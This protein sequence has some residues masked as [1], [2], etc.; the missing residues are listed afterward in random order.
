[1]FFR[2]AL[3]GTEAWVATPSAVSTLMDPHA[4]SERMRGGMHGSRVGWVSV[5]SRDRPLLD[6]HQRAGNVVRGRNGI[7]NAIHRTFTA[8]AVRRVAAC[9]PARGGISLLLLIRASDVRGV[10]CHARLVVEG[11]RSRSYIASRA[12]RLGDAA[13]LWHTTGRQ[14]LLTSPERYMVFLNRS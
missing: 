7:H 1:M 13:V 14:G 6:V 12:V 9:R 2:F 8:R 3:F 4:I 5:S 10:D 11:E